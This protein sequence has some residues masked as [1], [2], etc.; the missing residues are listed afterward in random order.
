MKKYLIM[1]TWGAFLGCSSVPLM[2][3]GNVSGLNLA[4]GFVASSGIPSPDEGEFLE[5]GVAKGIGR[6]SASGDPLDVI[7]GGYFFS[8]KTKELVWYARQSRL[9]TF[10]SGV[11]KSLVIYWFKPDGTLYQRSKK[12]SYD[13]RSAFL[14]KI[15]FD[16]ELDPGLRGNWRVRVWEKD[17]LVDDR[18]FKIVKSS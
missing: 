14:H 16:A 10:S 2:E 12:I 1:F 9:K 6:W 4:P 15:K 13:Y 7:G 11:A 5:V 8:D 3:T 18:V 17:R